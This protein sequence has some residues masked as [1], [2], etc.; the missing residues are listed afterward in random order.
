MLFSKFQ[1]IGNDYIIIDEFK[2]EV[3][4]E[5]QKSAIARLL[6]KRQFS[7]GAD[8][9][10]FVCPSTHEDAEIKMR[11]FN[12]DGSE[13]EM[14][15]NG[16]R[17]FAKYVYQKGLIRSLTMRI[18]TLGGI[19]IITLS[20]S[21]GVVSTI[22]VDMGEPKL[23]RSE[24]PMRGENT[25]VIN[26]P[27]IIGDISY[28]ITCVSMGNPHC[29]IFVDNVKDLDI[30]QGRLIE[31]HSVFPQRTNVEFIKIISSREIEMRVWERGVGETLACG[32]GACAATV[33]AFLN[34]KTDRKTTVHLLGGD[35]DLFWDASTNHVYMTGPATHVF[36]GEME[37]ENLIE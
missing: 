10:L 23:L 36:D 30:E 32:T 18:E 31:T 2:Q 19:K 37:L 20:T 1:G 13:A 5:K 16:I 21:E 22:Q 7:I 24:I 3:V 11:I 29:V 34:G 9:V 27:L 6:C 14:C 35:L 15:G 17:C 33:A 4:P 28:K 8:G 26:E 12:A 25:H